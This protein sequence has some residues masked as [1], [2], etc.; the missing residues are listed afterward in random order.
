[1]YAD[2]DKSQQATLLVSWC[3]LRFFW[4]STHIR[5]PKLPLHALL[6]GSPLDSHDHPNIGTPR[7]GPRS[8]WSLHLLLARSQ[9]QLT[10]WTLLPSA[11]L[12]HVS[13][14]SQSCANQ[15]HLLDTNCCWQYY[16]VLSYVFIMVS[17][18][19][20]SGS[21]P[22]FMLR[23]WPYLTPHFLFVL[24]KNV[25]KIFQFRRMDRKRTLLMTPHEILKDWN[26]SLAMGNKLFIE[27]GV[28]VA[29]RYNTYI[30]I[31]IYIYIFINKKNRCMLR[32]DQFLRMLKIQH[33][34]LLFVSFSYISMHIVFVP[35]R[36][37]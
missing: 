18:Y 32:T 9:Y 5:A 23:F 4:R 11:S 13:M 2:L 17:C 10:D 14:C 31:Y 6:C 24:G 3:W 1:M 8:H 16:D 27:K 29:V 12:N 15:T 19:R 22:G 33:A 28:S 7:Q 21:H 30:Y 35:G 36:V 26:M 20:W 25:Q 34:T 37:H